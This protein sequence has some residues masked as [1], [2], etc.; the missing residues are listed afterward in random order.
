[1]SSGAIAAGAKTVMVG[2]IRQ[3][4]LSRVLLPGIAPEEI[5]PA[6][7][8]PEL[9]NGVLR[10]RLGFEGLV[11]TDNSAMTGFT[12]VMPRVQALP[13]AIAAGNDMLLGNVD[14]ETDF[15]IL[16]DAAGHRRARPVRLLR[17]P[18]SPARRVQAA[19][20]P[21]ADAVAPSRRE[22][23]RDSNARTSRDH[24]PMGRQKKPA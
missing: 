12:S 20:S 14:V 11:V 5:L 1:M 16:L 7:L 2:H 22:R 10:E 18:H 24:T 21:A 13:R 19:G 17:G 6:S 9:I 4:A 15:G 8:A 23:R 3:P